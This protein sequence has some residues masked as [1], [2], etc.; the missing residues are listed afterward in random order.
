[1]RS[2]YIQNNY[3]DIFKAIID[4]FKPV[5]AVELGI[6]DGYS[7]MAIGLGLQ[8][9]GRGTLHSYDLF[10]D[11]QYKHGNEKQVRDLLFEYGLENVVTVIKQDAWKV[12]DLFNDGT[13]DFLHVDISNTG[14]TVRRIMAQWDQKMVTGGIICFEG[15]T[16]E[17]DYVDWMSKYNMPP[18]KTEMETN[19]IIKEKYIFGTY[20]KFPGLTMLLK[21]R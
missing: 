3:A 9:N 12:A 11:Y 20:L 21:K 14:E 15:G 5:T 7:T 8:K 13:V 10:D 6:L 4:G 16:A 2:S 19:P 1:M 17:R 18:I